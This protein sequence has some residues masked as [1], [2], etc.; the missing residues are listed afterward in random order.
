MNNITI[1]NAL[2]EKDFLW[3]TQTG[4]FKKITD[5]HTCHL[6]NTF[7]MIWNH[8]VPEEMKVLPYKKY[9]FGKYYTNDY[10]REAIKN[11]ILEL[12]SRQ[13]LSSVQLAE[14]L[15]MKSNLQRYIDYQPVNESIK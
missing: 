5:M 2:Q 1:F 14:L 12:Q 8:S 11:M 3:R 9:S 7:K 6:Y 10:V 4:E 15:Q 13:D